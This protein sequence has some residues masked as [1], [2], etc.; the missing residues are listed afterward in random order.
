MPVKLIR[1]DFAAGIRPLNRRREKVHE[2]AE[3]RKFAFFR[4]GANGFLS[5]KMDEDIPEIEKDCPDN[6]FLSHLLI[7][8][9]VKQLLFILPVGN[10]LDP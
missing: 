7:P 6:D 8:K 4:E 5:I 2:Y 1:R 3:Y 10:D 9:P